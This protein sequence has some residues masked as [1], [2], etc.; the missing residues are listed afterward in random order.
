MYLVSS[1]HHTLD[2]KQRRETVRL[3]FLPVLPLKPIT[4]LQ[5]FRLSVLH[6][7]VNELNPTS[8]KVFR[9]SGSQSKPLV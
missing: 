5:L 8:F 9:I 2:F 3:S 4:L 1:P 7:G 6:K